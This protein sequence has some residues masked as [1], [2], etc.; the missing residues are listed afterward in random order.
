MTLMET[1]DQLAVDVGVLAERSGYTVKTRPH[2]P[3]GGDTQPKTPQER[4]FHG[5]R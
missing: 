4:L 3:C 5:E 1:A 2:S